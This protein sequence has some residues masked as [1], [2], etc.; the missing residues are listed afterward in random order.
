MIWWRL[1][2]RQT[3]TC[4]KRSSSKAKTL[5][6]IISCGSQ[7]LL[8]LPNSVHRDL[9]VVTPEKTSLSSSISWLGIDQSKSGGFAT[10]T[11]RT[12]LH[13][14]ERRYMVEQSQTVQQHCKPAYTWMQSMPLQ[15]DS[16]NLL[17]YQDSGYHITDGSARNKSC[18]SRILHSFWFLST[19]YH[20]SSSSVSPFCCRNLLE[21]SNSRRLSSKSSTP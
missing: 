12:N 17:G 15:F 4:P 19:I 10:V 18:K 2:W 13:C 20:S 5:Q 8:R 3:L 1:D 11:K 21:K 9:M 16:W 7:S 14:I 6:S